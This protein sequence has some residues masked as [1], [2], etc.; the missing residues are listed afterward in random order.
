M[1]DYELSYKKQLILCHREAEGVPTLHLSS[2]SSL[3]TFEIVVLSFPLLGWT[4]S[5]LFIGLR[6]DLDRLLILTSLLDK[7]RTEV[8]F[9]EYDNLCRWYSQKFKNRC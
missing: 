7:Y 4:A 5:L 6:F 9:T 8:F 2:S 1:I 3:F